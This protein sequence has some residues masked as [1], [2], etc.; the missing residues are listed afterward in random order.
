M[1]PT[2]E[3]IA[4]KDGKDWIHCCLSDQEAHAIQLDAIAINPNPTEMNGSSSLL[5]PIMSHSMKSH[6]I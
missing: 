4:I 3:A 2:I 1:T 6:I 5:S